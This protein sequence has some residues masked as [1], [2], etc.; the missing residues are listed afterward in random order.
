[1]K[2]KRNQRPSYLEINRRLPTVEECENCKYQDECGGGEW[3]V[4]SRKPKKPK[5]KKF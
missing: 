1:M 2:A 3:C 4:G 5:E